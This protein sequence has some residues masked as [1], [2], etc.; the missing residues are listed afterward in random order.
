MRISGHNVNE[1]FHDALWAI[2]TSGVIEES[3]AGRVKT[4]PEPVLIEHDCPQERVLF[5]EERKENPVFHLMEALWMMAGRNDSEW[6]A[7]FNPRMRDFAEPNGRIHGAYGYRWR[8]S[9]GM[10]QI[11]EVI[12]MLRVDPTTRRAVIGMW[13]PEW[14]LNS[15]GKKDLPC[16]THIY[17]RS[18]KNFLDMTVCNRS[19]D[20]VWGALGSNVVHFSIL[21]EFIAHAVGQQMGSMFQFTNNLHIY[22]RHWKYLDVPPD[23]DHYEDL[24]VRAYPLIVGDYPR[25]LIECTDFVNGKRTNFSEPFF[26]HVAV[27]I[28]QRQPEL[29]AGCDW[30]LACQ[31]YWNRIGG[32]T[33]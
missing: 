26:T 14:D 7:Q 12:K 4:I 19:N 8:Q 9:F 15:P 2:K 28:I 29:I 13:H 21:H 30:K 1:T 33:A 5:C 31:R 16:N 17:F 3:R 25:W 23:C 27:P 10:D 20:L 22:E 11:R 18:R 32:I 6:V 24:Q